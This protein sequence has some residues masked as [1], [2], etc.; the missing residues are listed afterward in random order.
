MSVVTQTYILASN[1]DSASDSPTVILGC[2]IKDP[3]KPGSSISKSSV[4]PIGASDIQLGDKEDWQKTSA[5][6]RSGK[7]GVWLSASNSL[8]RGE[9]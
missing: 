4:V 9:I 7:V 3:K 5:Q 2:I 8:G 6:L 1:W